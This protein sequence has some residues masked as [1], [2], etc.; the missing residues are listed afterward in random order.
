MEHRFGSDLSRVSPFPSPPSQKMKTTKILKALEKIPKTKLVIINYNIC[1]N[2]L[3]LLERQV[4]IMFVETRFS[5][6]CYCV[7][8][9]QEK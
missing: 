8:D 1:S 3:E 6:S 5:M 7:S 2:C 4:Q 9:S